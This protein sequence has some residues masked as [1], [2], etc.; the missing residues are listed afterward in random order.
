MKMCRASG[1]G[2]DACLDQDP[3]LDAE[4]AD[5]PVGLAAAVGGRAGV[6]DPDPVCCLV[7][8]YVRVPEYHEVSGRVAAAHPGGAA[9][10]GT[11]VVDH[12]H[13][14]AAEVELQVR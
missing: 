8:R 9:G 14:Q 3:I 6:E 4:D 5:G 2:D 10:R 1:D 11:T 7:Q 12:C 13:P